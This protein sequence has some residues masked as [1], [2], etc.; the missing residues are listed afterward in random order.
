M[1]ADIYIPARRAIAADHGL[2]FLAPGIDA[3]N[4]LRQLKHAV[5]FM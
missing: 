3:I 4:E 5:E 1:V 2:A